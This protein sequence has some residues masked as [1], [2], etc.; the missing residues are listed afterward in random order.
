MFGFSLADWL[1][2][3]GVMVVVIVCVAISDMNK[4]KQG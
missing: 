2:I 4:K 1:F 3:A